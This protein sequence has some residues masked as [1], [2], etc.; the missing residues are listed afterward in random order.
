MR[1]PTKIISLIRGVLKNSPFSC[2]TLNDPQAKRLDAYITHLEDA[3]ACAED[4]VARKAEMLNSAFP[5][6]RRKT[7]TP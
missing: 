1:R 6:A 2:V 4:Q 3:L 7:S 5:P